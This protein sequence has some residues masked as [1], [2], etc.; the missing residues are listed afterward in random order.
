MQEHHIPALL[1]TG[2]FRSAAFTCSAAGRYRMRYDAPDEADLAR[3]LATHAERLRAEFTGRFPAGIQLSRE[4]WAVPGRGPHR[5]PRDDDAAPGARRVAPAPRPGGAQRRG[6]GHVAL[7]ADG[8]TLG[9][10]ASKVTLC[11]LILLATWLTIG[12]LGRPS[13]RQALAIGIL[14]L[15]LTLAFEFLAGHYAFGKACLSRR[16]TTI[17]AL[18]A[19]AKARLS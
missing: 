13:A 7:A 2:C 12:W 19:S 17:R 11:G 6:E 10:A 16:P 15:A 3:Y 14:W 18:A 8:R 5:R 1:A 9:R 4:V